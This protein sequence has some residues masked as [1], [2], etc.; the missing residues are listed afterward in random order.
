MGVPAIPY[1]ESRRSNAKPGKS[2]VANHSA[3]FQHHSSTLLS[4]L[5]PTNTT[6][7]PLHWEG[8]GWVDDDDMEDGGREEGGGR[9]GS[10]KLKVSSSSSCC[11]RSPP[12]TEAREAEYFIVADVASQ[13]YRAHLPTSTFHLNCKRLHPVNPICGVMAGF[14]STVN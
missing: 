5:H 13:G 12:L 10:P 9:R 1:L 2:L 3:S 14:H 7:R 4:S 6:Q 8:T 11:T